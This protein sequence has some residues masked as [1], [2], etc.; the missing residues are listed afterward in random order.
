MR[1]VSTNTDMPA[2]ITPG[3]TVAYTR[4]AGE[5]TEA[6]GYS[7]KL[8]VAGVSVLE[9]ITGVASGS[10]WAF[11]IPATATAA[12]SMGVHQY[13]E[14]VTKGAEVYVLASGTVEVL[15][16]IL[17]AGAGDMLTWEQRALAAVEAALE[18]RLTADQQAFSIGG[19]AVTKIPVM[20]LL[21]IRDQLRNA[22]RAG[23]RAG[24]FGAEVRVEFTGD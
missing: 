11:T 1:P 13:R 16:N 3:T 7:A 2:T 17:K 18:G 5:Y 21:R 15:A 14:L 8:Y 22:V 23:T 4:E 20:E 24:K 9:A 10:G 19:R 12:L 6:A